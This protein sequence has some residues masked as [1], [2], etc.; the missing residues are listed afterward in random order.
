MALR[1]L[2]VCLH[3]WHQ[4]L[5]AFFRCGNS[6][7][8]SS[9]ASDNNTTAG[10]AAVAVILPRPPATS[11]SQH[12]SLV[13]DHDNFKAWIEENEIGY[14]YHNVAV[15]LLTLQKQRKKISRRYALQRT[16]MNKLERCRMV[17]PSCT[18]CD[19]EDLQQELA[20]LNRR[21]HWPMLK[22]VMLYN[23][24]KGSHY[25]DSLLRG[26][27]NNAWLYYN[28]ACYICYS[29]DICPSE[30]ILFLPCSHTIS[31][32]CFY[33]TIELYQPLNREGDTLLL[34][35]HVSWH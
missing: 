31:A 32:S 6:L 11:S 8:I 23:D 25:N 21:I 14:Y 28:Y 1:P 24:Y 35:C 13:I 10:A 26:L 33:R 22:I 18:G 7:D 19:L 3:R 12:A 9:A 29:V 27:C 4:A 5:N 16:I 20:R 17:D 34:F 30:I 15:D 2:T